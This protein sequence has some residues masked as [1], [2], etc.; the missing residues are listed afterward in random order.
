MI[1]KERENTE[2]F[3]FSSQ[4][5]IDEFSDSQG[6]TVSLRKSF[7]GRAFNNWEEVQKAAKSCWAEGIYTCQEF[8]NRLKDIELPEVKDTRR[9]TRYS[10][11]D[12]DEVDF[13]K[14]YSGDEKFFRK[15]E[16]EDSTGVKDVSIYIDTTTPCN[17][18][19]SDILWRGA[20]AIALAY[21]L[22]ARGYR[23]ELWVVN[24][25]KLYGGE[26]TRVLTSCCL[27]KAS[28][29]LDLSTLVNA[30]SGWMYR[31]KI[32]SVLENLCRIRGKQVA[33]GLGECTSP[34]E[35]DLDLIHKD[36]VRIYVSGVFSFD[37]AARLIEAE[38][39]KIVG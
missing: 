12:G 35:M 23:V 39:A 1:R 10:D 2:L 14:M 29:P 36:D 18:D 17:K 5:D 32:F 8:I 33:L 28:D 31:T 6:E 38:V 13:E 9:K 25:S 27:K 24:G 21:L 22:E 20:A 11:D 3:V 37:G 30:V 16:R 7:V 26:S 34:S 15:T 4:A 19:S